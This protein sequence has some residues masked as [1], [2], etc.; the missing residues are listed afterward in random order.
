MKYIEKGEAPDFY[1]KAI[2]QLDENALW[3][4]FRNPEKQDVKEHMLNN[5][6]YS[7]CCYC[8]TKISSDVSQSHIEHLEPKSRDLSRLS[9][10]YD[11]L[12][13]SCQG[14]HCN[15]ANE[16][17]RTICGHKKDKNYDELK[18]LNPTQLTDI[19]EYF[20]YNKNTAEIEASTKD[21]VKANYMIELLNLNGLNNRLAEARLDTLVSLMDIYEEDPDS[22]ENLVYDLLE[23]HSQE[24][25]SFLR[26]YFDYSA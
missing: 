8:E 22:Y 16:K 11:N 12:A 10:A 17:G 7:L 9:F 23:D 19:H 25:I 18:F 3:E 2:E 20:N 4:D 1:L 5:E 21:E 6:Q 15:P 14:T 24:H 26:F 13:V